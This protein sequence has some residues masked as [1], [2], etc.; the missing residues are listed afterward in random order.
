MVKLEWPQCAIAVAAAIA[1][2]ACAAAAPDGAGLG[3]LLPLSPISLQLSPIQESTVRAAA[4]PGVL[5]LQGQGQS[6]NCWQQLLLQPLHN[7]DILQLRSGLP[8]GASP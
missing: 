3:L 2:V 4:A 5:G 7:V 6:C 8:T 1:A